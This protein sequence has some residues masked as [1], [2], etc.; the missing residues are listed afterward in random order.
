MRHWLIA[1]FDCR[2]P[3]TQEQFLTFGSN[4]LLDIL[5]LSTRH[6]FISRWDIRGQDMLADAPVCCN[7]RQWA[8]QRALQCAAVSIAVCC[9]VHVHVLHI[10]RSVYKI[11]W[12]SGLW[13]HENSFLRCLFRYSCIRHSFIRH[14]S[15]SP[16]T[17]DGAHIGFTNMSDDKSWIHLRSWRM[18]IHSSDKL[19]HPQ[20]AEIDLTL[21]IRNT[22]LSAVSA[23]APLMEEL[24]I[25]ELRPS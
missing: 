10:R 19:A 18:D 5:I 17:E 8:L 25:S 4:I 24:W 22:G 16:L 13:G 11:Y 9:S 12:F 14:V 21:I 1:H 2:L 23:T 3:R 6:S 7:E 15:A 20:W